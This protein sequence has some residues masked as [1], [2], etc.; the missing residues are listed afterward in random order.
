MLRAVTPV[1]AVLRRINHG[2]AALCWA[3]LM[4]SA[5]AWVWQAACALPPSPG[6]TQFRGAIFAHRAQT[7]GA[8]PAPENTLA[9]IRA[10]AQ[11]GVRAVEVDVRLSADGRAVLMHDDTLD[12]TTDGAGPVSERTLADLRALSADAGIAD[13]AGEPV[14]TLDEAV[15]LARALGLWLELDVK[16]VETSVVAEEIATVLARHDAFATTF[17]SSF[18]PQ[19]LYAVRSRE[20]RVITALAIRPDATGIALVDR[21][22]GS[23]WLPEWLGVGLVEPHRDL[24]SAERVAAWRRRGFVVNAWTVN[25]A[26]DKAYFQRLGIAITTNCPHAACPD[27]PSDSM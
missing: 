27:D 1:R 8:A 6:A 18:Y 23:F 11:A 26:E 15:A 21:L 14:P 12:R 20:P 24:V 7:G 9:A 22:L 2:I 19:V 17:A 4:A 25:A 16:N 5:G 3:L 13:Y 10:A